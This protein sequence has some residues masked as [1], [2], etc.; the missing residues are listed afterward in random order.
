MRAMQARGITQRSRL[1]ILGNS[2][3]DCAGLVDDAGY[4]LILD[5]VFVKA[6][7][8]EPV[9]SKEGPVLI[10]SARHDG[11][12]ALRPGS[13]RD[14]FAELEDAALGVRSLELDDASLVQEVV[15]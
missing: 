11:P 2:P 13:L 9:L 12:R 1:D 8:V 7:L 3:K 14:V 5:R 10:T 4:T 15:E 6:Q